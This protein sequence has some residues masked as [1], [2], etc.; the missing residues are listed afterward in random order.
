MCKCR[1]GCVARGRESSGTSG[2][3]EENIVLANM[4]FH[5]MLNDKSEE[6]DPDLPLL[7]M[8]PHFDAVKSTDRAPR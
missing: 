6:H 7:Y 3:K 1:M 5:I 8:L 4:S 2:S